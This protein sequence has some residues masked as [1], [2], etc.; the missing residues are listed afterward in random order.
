[1]KIYH[2]GKH[3]SGFTLAELLVAMAITVVLISLVVAITGTALDT[4]RGA[5]NEVRASRQAKIMLDALG[6][7]LESFVVRANNDS[8]WLYASTSQEK[9]GPEGQPSPN[10]ATLVFLTAASD[11][12]GG[13]IGD[14]TEDKGGDIST[15]GYQLKFEDPVFA[16]QDERYSK[17]V[18]YR[19]LIDPDR[20]FQGVI[21]RDDLE[22]AYQ[23]YAGAGSDPANFMCENIYEF[24]VVF[25]VRYLDQSGE[26]QIVRVPVI[27]SGA[28]N[29]AQK[30]VIAG[31]EIEVD[32]SKPV[33]GDGAVISV[34]ISVTVL[35]DTGMRQIRNR[36]FSDDDA[37]AKFLAENSYP[38]SKSVII[39]QP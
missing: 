5:R 33:F 18:L 37:K 2:P 16:D 28:L 38:F 34:D 19:N 20:T 30:F 23:G 36:T 29:A 24:S 11:R 6:R 39:P 26:D 4:W 27:D 35:S 7:D 25:V 32:D 15:V 10:A 3:H 13:N 22:Q 12:Y 17:F 14:S 8:E 21:G 31:D 9:I 1:M